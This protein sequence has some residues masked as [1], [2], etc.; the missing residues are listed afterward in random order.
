[1]YS[2]TIGRGTGKN[3]KSVSIY[4]NTGGPDEITS[5][6]PYWLMQLGRELAESDQ[7]G[8]VVAIS[9]PTSNFASI[10]VLLGIATAKPPILANVDDHWALLRNPMETEYVRYQTSGQFWSGPLRRQRDARYGSVP[11]IG[12]RTFSQPRPMILTI[13]HIMEWERDL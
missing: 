6:W 3:V 1:M 13:Q 7:P 10:F 4:D 12:G 5:Q 9:L 8:R 2:E 11:R